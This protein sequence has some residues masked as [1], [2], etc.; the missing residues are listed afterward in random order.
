MSKSTREL[1]TELFEKIGEIKLNQP[2]G[3]FGATSG[4]SVLQ[5]LMKSV[6]DLIQALGDSA[7]YEV[8]MQKYEVL[9]S[10]IDTAGITG[11]IS[12]AEM[13]DYYKLV[14]DIWATIESEKKSKD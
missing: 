5:D 9:V 12:E 7:E 8:V 4:Q 6:T 1:V 10:S 13:A 11:L 14:D 3:I 2:A